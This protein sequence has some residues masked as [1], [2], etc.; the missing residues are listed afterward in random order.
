MTARIYLAGPITGASYTD[1]RFGWRNDLG[2]KLKRGLNFSVTLLSPMRGTDDHA[3]AKAL[4]APSAA[5]KNPV[6]TPKGTICRDIAD[7]KKADLVVVC[8]LEAERTSIGTMMEMGIAK[9][10]GVP[11]L[12]IDNGNPYHDHAWVREFADYRVSSLQAAVGVIRD[13]LGEG[14]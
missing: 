10:L 13:H 12:L 3:G 8:L 7:I 9:T 6:L 14:L 4:P 11:I 2:V 1:A 5:D